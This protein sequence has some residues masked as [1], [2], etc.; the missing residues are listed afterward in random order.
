MGLKGLFSGA[1][2]VSFRECMP[3]DI[4]G[5][6][7][8]TPAGG[9]EPASWV[10]R[11]TLKF[12]YCL[13]IIVIWV[14]PKKM[15][16][17]NHPMFNRVWNHYF[18]HP[19]LGG[20]IPYLGCMKP[21]KYW[22][23]LP[24][25]WCRISAINSIIFVWFFL[26]AKKVFGNFT[27]L[28]V[29]FFFDTTKLAFGKDQ[30]FRLGCWIISSQAFWHRKSSWESW[31]SDCSE[32]WK[33]DGWGDD[34][35]RKGLFFPYLAAGFIYTWFLSNFCKYR[36]H[37]SEKFRKVLHIGVYQCIFIYLFYI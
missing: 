26:E 8:L 12:I 27:S 24:I 29:S 10:N 4:L 25:S 32:W 16:P 37:F 7:P 15:V 11:W 20:K 36:W 17:P 35:S 28:R 14:F 31:S 34:F 13:F 21:Y 22:D 18:H 6:L 9:D 3:Y 2:A 19:F 1:F 30:R 5:D 33:W 23:K